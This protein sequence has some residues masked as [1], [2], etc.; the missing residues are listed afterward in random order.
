MLRCLFWNIN[1]KPLVAPLRSLCDSLDVDVLI[2][3]ECTIAGTVLLQGLNNR[4]LRTFIRADELSERIIFLHRLPPAAVRP[5]SDFPYCSIRAIEPPGHDEILIAAIHHMSKL[6]ADD[7][8]QTSAMNETAENI[9]AAEDKREHKRTIVVGDLNM[10]PFELSVCSADGLHAVMCK[11]IAAKRDR[12]VRGLPRDFFYNPM[13]NFLGD[14]TP[15]PPGT[16]YYRGA[17]VSYFWNTFDQV[18]FRPELL[19]YYR[20]ENI[21]VIDELDGVSLLG[22]N[23]LASEFSDHLPLFFSL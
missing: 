4:G 15:G 13:W 10:N 7:Y 23:G 6:H 18:L 1:R 21:R 17:T 2:L 22:A 20:H 14:E 9:R 3:A 8:D 19:P 11:Q 16:Y 12:I 5:V